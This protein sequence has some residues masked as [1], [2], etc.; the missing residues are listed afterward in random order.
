MWNNVESLTLE[1]QRSSETA[2]LVLVSI[3]V[4]WER[5]RLQL[6][7]RGT[8]YR[9][10]LRP[11]SGVQ[12]ADAVESTKGSMDSYSDPPVGNLD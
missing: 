4:T 1:K 11:P 6:E 5:A 12:V 10:T 8:T 9:R 3:R 2:L 7:G